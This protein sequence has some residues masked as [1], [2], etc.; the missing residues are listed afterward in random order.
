MSCPQGRTF[1]G[2]VVGP[3]IAAGTVYIV[4]AAFNNPI[5]HRLPMEED[6]NIRNG[7]NGFVSAAIDNQ[8][9]GSRGGEN[10]NHHQAVPLTAAEVLSMYPGEIWAPTPRQSHPHSS[11]Y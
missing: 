8:A 4:A 11:L 2:T 6:N 7:G 1:G 3:L 10:G 9:S 5:Y